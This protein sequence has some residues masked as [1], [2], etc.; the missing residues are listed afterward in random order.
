LPLICSFILSFPPFQR[1]SPAGSAAAVSRG[2]VLRVQAP[3]SS[4]SQDD[5]ENPG[6]RVA[7]LR[8]LRVLRVASFK[9]G[10]RHTVCPATTS[11]TCPSTEEEEEA[12]MC[13]LWRVLPPCTLAR[14]TSFASQNSAHCLY[15]PPLAGGGRGGG[16]GRGRGGGAA[17]A[18]AFVF[19]EAAGA[20]VFKEYNC[21]LFSMNTTAAAAADAIMDPQLRRLSGCHRLPPARAGLG[22]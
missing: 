8:V 13:C 12:C 14:G 9:V 1:Q 18:A 6:E 17:A 20:F 3:P 2:A 4:R 15:L 21:K 10:A 7:A 11:T 19:I 5:I 22:R 16:G